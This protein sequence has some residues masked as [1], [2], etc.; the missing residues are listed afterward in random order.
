M[1]ILVADTWPAPKTRGPAGP[2]GS[3]HPPWRPVSPEGLLPAPP[4]PPGARPDVT[5]VSPGELASRSHA[6][7][8]GAC[9]GVRGCGGRKETGFMT[10]GWE[11]GM[12]DGGADPKAGGR[13]QA[14]TPPALSICVAAPPWPGRCQQPQLGGGGGGSSA[15]AGSTHPSSVAPCSGSR[16]RGQTPRP[17]AQ[18]CSQ[19]WR[20]FQ[21]RPKCSQ[22]L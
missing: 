1:G 2:M 8:P 19:G 22:G 16:R 5:E 12:S 7:W 20:T 9:R 4:D 3:A 10:L 13:P 17:A 14:R 18:T 21:S 6:L 11:A 15:H